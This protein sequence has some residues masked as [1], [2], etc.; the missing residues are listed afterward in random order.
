MSGTDHVSLL[1]SAVDDLISEVASRP[2]VLQVDGKVA[3]LALRFQS[4]SD[5]GRTYDLAI[6]TDGR[7][8]CECWPHYDGRRCPHVDA[9]LRLHELENNL[10]R[11]ALE[12]QS[13]ASAVK[14]SRAQQR[15][16]STRPPLQLRELDAT[17]AEIVDANG[18]VAFRAASEEAVDWLREIVHQF[19]GET[20]PGRDSEAA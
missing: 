2:E 11:L 20:A 13:A 12:L 8:S 19:G 9:L 10:A 7:I 5:P 14:A 18:T 15:S 17:H 3:M 16:A 4:R 1:L 6:Q